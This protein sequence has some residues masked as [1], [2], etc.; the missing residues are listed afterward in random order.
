MGLKT[1]KI[2]DVFKMVSLAHAALYIV[3]LNS[4]ISKLKL[5]LFLSNNKPW[6]FVCFF[7][8][9]VKRDFNKR[10]ANLALE[11]TKDPQEENGPNKA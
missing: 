11:Q 5:F 7:L 3:G 4:I 10:P 1:L 6:L 8:L 9:R 2:S